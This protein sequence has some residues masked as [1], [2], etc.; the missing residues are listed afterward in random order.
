MMFDL[1]QIVEYGGGGWFVG[2][3]L[4]DVLFLCMEDV[5]Y[6]VYVIDGVVFFIIGEQY[7]EGVRVVWMSGDELFGGYYEGGYV[8]F[9]VCCIVVVQYVIMDLW[10]EWVVGLGGDWFGWYY[11]GV[12]KQYEYWCVV[13]VGGLQ[14]V[15]FVKVQV[16]VVEFGVLQ[17]FGQQCLV[18]G[19][20]GG[21]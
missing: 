14:I 20:V 1:Q 12:V 10:Y 19:I 9:Y 6:L 11:V 8:V 3:V 16:F 15:D 4:V 2:D 7:C 17:V 13:F 21:Y 18:V 5:G